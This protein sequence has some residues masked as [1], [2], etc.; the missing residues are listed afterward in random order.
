MGANGNPT[1]STA[2]ED[3]IVKN[4]GQMLANFIGGIVQQNIMNL[5]VR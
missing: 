2:V 3:M 4:S 5:N 1:M